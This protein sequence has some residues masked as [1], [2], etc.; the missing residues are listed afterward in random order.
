[1]TYLRIKANSP[2]Q[3]NYIFV[4]FTQNNVKFVNIFPPAIQ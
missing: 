3:T 1:M 4:K 2:S